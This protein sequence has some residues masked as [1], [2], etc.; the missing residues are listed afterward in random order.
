MSPIEKISPDDPRLTAYALGEMAAEER[1]EFERR[2]EQDAEA[3]ALVG[4]I[5][6]LAATL[7]PA[8]AAEPAPAAG[9][10]VARRSA[11]VLRFPQAYF[12]AAGLVAACFGVYF[13]VHE[14][15]ASSEPEGLTVQHV[16]AEKS[17]GSM[18]GGA[19]GLADADA[20]PMAAGTAAR[21]SGREAFQLVADKPGVAERFFSTAEAATSTFPLRVGRGSLAEVR[22]LLRRGARP[23][24]EIVHVAELINA[25]N[26]AW[27]EAAPEE[28][29]VT[30]LEETASPWSP[31]HRL[32]RVGVKG[33]GP[34]GVVA[35]REAR[36]RVDFNPACVRAW[37]LIGFEQ[38]GAAVGVDGLATGE[39]LRGG[40][41]VTALY[42]V[43]PAENAGR[44]DD[45]TLLTLALQYRSGDGAQ[46]RSVTRRLAS[47]GAAFA[48]ASA[49]M[50][51]IAAVAAFGLHLR[52]S[53]LQAPVPVE[54]M[55]A[56]AAEGAGRDAVRAEWVDLMRSARGRAR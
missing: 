7:E 16:A 27:P 43:L 19:D 47:D 42:E 36:V 38:D 37:R 11:P 33:A 53:P 28:A 40:D 21:A 6:A 44:G 51:F 4:E 54:E 1:A 22:A 15:R 49:D 30:L 41:T 52:E 23:A 3:R 9:P 13:I 26:Y 18:A 24:R 39:T 2:L 56:W 17:A 31:G 34:A 55:A 25:F 5:R 8:L 32:V 45:R 46:E 10:V 50:K 48:R 20:E 35:V 12:A 29:L 14:R